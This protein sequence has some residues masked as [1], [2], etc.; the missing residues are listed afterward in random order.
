MKRIEDIFNSEQF[1][2][3][4]TFIEE[5]REHTLE[6]QIALAQIPAWSNHEEK[7]AAR[8]AEMVKEIGYENVT[9]DE[10]SN[11]YTV[12][13]GRGEGPKVLITA[14]CDTVFPLDTDL[15]V[16]RTPDG[17]ICCPGICDD[18][19]GMAE[20]LSILRAVKACGIR[21]VG[22]IIIGSDV[23]EENLG[24]MRGIRHLCKTLPDLDGFISI[25]LPNAN[26]LTHAGTG[27]LR[28]KIVFHGVGGHSFMAFGT[29][30]P[31]YALGG[32]IAKIAAFT[33]PE[34][35]KTTFNVGVVSGGTGAT[36]IAREMEMQ[37]DIRSNGK[38]ELAELERKLRAAV[39][40]A[41][42]EENARWESPDKLTYTIEV[43]G[44]LPVAPQSGD[45]TIARVGRA[46][47]KQ[48]GIEHKPNPE[49]AAPTD[50]NMAIVSGIPAITVGRGGI[51]GGGH[52]LE[53]WFK[54]VDEFKSPQRTLLI[55]L[56]LVG[57]E[58]VSTPILERRAEKK[59][60]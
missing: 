57:L 18:T 47:L 33:V 15:T 24:G 36:A 59:G 35:P 44:D 10:V 6:Q 31:A 55:L 9:V 26:A 54:P 52:S 4:L 43:I 49:G 39:H 38:E 30:N 48:M 22:D 58:G 23:G 34:T 45:V 16:R 50:S 27:S 17:K 3:A 53:E 60:E 14:H 5:D 56:A 25:D 21:T 8:F 12:I 28:L 41:A 40:E 2:R 13:K 11:V 29:P 1:K 37:V 42:E 19:R 51:G 46:C 32:A 20:I 7:K